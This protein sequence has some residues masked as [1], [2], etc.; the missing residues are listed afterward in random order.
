MSGIPTHGLVW[1]HFTMWQSLVKKEKRVELGKGKRRG[2]KQRGKKISGE[3]RQEQLRRGRG[4]SR[5]DSWE[6][7]GGE[8]EG[9]RERQKIPVMLHFLL[10]KT[11]KRALELCFLHKLPKTLA[12]PPPLPNIKPHSPK[13]KLEGGPW[14]FSLIKRTLQ[15]SPQR[16]LTHSLSPP[17]PAPSPWCSFLAGFYEPCSCLNSKTSPN[18]TPGWSSDWGSPG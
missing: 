5:E 7:E 13:G 15:D 14:V 4:E 9:K 3:V 1:C 6:G 10:G 18:S 12:Q 2:E 11:P 17:V 16:T 8:M